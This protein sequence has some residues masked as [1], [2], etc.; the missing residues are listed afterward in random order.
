MNYNVYYYNSPYICHYGI[1]GMKWGVRRYQNADGTLTAAGKKRQRK[2]EKRQRKQEKKAE[3]S[4][5]KASKADRKKA[6]K[7]RRQLPDE[8]LTSRIKRLEQEKKLKNLTD[9]DIAPGKTAVKNFLKTTGGRVLT[10]AAVGGLVYAGHYAMT[11]KLPKHVP[12]SLA[13]VDWDQAANYMFPIPN[14]KK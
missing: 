12:K 14:K 1:L 4:A 11:G 7:N 10:T 3:K 8:E 2:Q 6:F 5:I 9:E 13:D